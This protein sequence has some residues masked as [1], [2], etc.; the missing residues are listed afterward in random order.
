VD[1]RYGEMQGSDASK[2]QGKFIV[3]RKEDLFFT[4]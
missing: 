2:G 4:R 3:P 1:V